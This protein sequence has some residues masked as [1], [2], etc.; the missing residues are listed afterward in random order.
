MLRMTPCN[1][2]WRRTATTRLCGART[3]SAA[4]R[5]RVSD[6]KARRR[7]EYGR[8]GIAAVV[9]AKGYTVAAFD[10]EKGCTGCATC[11]QLC[12]EIAIEVYRDK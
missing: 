7:T 10:E 2:L 6:T 8:K 4:G 9:E 12:P 3:L 5:A 11:A 1:M